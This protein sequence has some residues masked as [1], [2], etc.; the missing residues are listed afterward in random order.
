MYNPPFSGDSEYVELLNISDSPVVL[1][2]PLTAEPWRFTDDPDNPGIDFFFPTDSP[3]TLEAGEYL[4]LVNNS[5]AFYARYGIPAGVQVFEWPAGKLD[6]AGEKIQL[7]MPG[8]VDLQGRRYWIRV[9]RVTYSDG[10][11]SDDTPEATD[12]WP[13]QPDGAG[14]SL[15]RINPSEYGNDPANWQAATPSPG[16]F[17]P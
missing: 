6:N 7:S 4:L 3:V 12:P 14:Y 11:H 16:L 15:S 5:A 1:Y 10:S 9:D 2:D 8:D 17:N 13:A